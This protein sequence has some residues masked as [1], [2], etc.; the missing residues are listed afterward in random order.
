MKLAVFSL[1]LVD[2][3][4]TYFSFYRDGEEVSISKEALNNCVFTNSS[5]GEEG[6]IPDLAYALLKDGKVARPIMQQWIRE[7]KEKFTITW[8]VPEGSYLTDSL[9]NIFSMEN[10][11]VVGKCAVK[12]ESFSLEYSKLNNS[13]ITHT[14]I[15][16]I[17]SKE[18]KGGEVTLTVIEQRGREPLSTIT[19][20]QPDEFGRRILTMENAL[21]EKI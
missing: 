9:G 3:S 8:N 4:I 16:D 14:T 2:Y 6:K 7:E 18:P 10:I 11:K 12:R 15:S 1:S 20:P 5:N 13:H 21:Q 17:V 19:L